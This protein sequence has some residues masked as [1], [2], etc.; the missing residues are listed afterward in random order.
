MV[1]KIIKTLP[2][3]NGHSPLFLYFNCRTL[4]QQVVMKNRAL[5]FWCLC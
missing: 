3:E 4:F 1:Q 2:N 5:T